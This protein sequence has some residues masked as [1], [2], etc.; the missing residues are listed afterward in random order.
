MPI[1]N[2]LSAGGRGKRVTVGRR[3]EVAYSPVSARATVY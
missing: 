2:L 1:T 3:T